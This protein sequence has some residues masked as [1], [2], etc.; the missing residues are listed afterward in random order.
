MATSLAGIE[1][2]RAWLI[3]RR[4]RKPSTLLPVFIALLF[5]Y[6]SL[7]PGQIPKI[8]SSLEVVTEFLGSTFLPTFM[9]NL[10]A[11]FLALWGGALPA[12]TYRGIIQAFNWFCP[13]LP[14]LNWLMKA[15]TGI[16]VPVVGLVIIQEISLAK[17][18][19]ARYRRQTGKGLTGWLITSIGMVIMLWFFLGV[20][21][22]HP[23]VI[24]T[25]SMRPVIEVGDVVIVARVNPK[26]LKVGDVVQ[27]RLKE[28]TIPTVHRI[29]DTRREG[30][31]LLYITKGDA[32]NYPDTEPVHPEQVTGKQ[33]FIIPKAGWA[34]I[35]V[36]QL[37]S[38][39]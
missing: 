26:L 21:P 18:H 13:V 32:N 37:L 10:L 23:T 9:E 14:D 3:N 35:A 31:K 30:N 1:L 8:S 27:F 11:S 15:F 6:F 5:T 19:L 38:K 33:V 39:G 16:I 20:F 2:S 12:L 29:I 28:K 4:A 34:S 22:V 17:S 24:F 25:G 36:K 7:P